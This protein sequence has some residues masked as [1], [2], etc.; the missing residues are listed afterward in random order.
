MISLMELI[1]LNNSELA[2]EMINLS[3]PTFITQYFTTYC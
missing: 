3:H 1:S 2:A